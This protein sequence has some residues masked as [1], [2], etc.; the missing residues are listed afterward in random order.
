[1]ELNYDKIFKKA[2]EAYLEGVEI[3]YLEPQEFDKHL[4]ILTE[5]FKDKTVKD[6]RYKTPPHIFSFMGI[7]FVKEGF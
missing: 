7:D 5:E 1:M 2:H 6:E 3:I 4:V